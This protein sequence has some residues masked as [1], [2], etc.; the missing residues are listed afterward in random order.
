[1]LCSCSLFGGCLFLLDSLC[2]FLLSLSR[3][4]FVFLSKVFYIL[5][6]PLLV[7]LSIFSGL[8]VGS[9]LF[10]ACLTHTPTQRSKRITD[11]HTTLG[12]PLFCALVSETV[13]DGEGRIGLLLESFET[14]FFFSWL[15]CFGVSYVFPLHR[16][17]QLI[18]RQDSFLHP[19]RAL[20]S[21]LSFFLSL[22]LCVCVFFLFFFWLCYSCLR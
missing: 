17:P 11:T 19:V 1:M 13:L 9:L 12:L 20:H 16:S 22:S 18:S 5:F 15:L 10:E 7:C 21:S 14:N 8:L 2:M 6:C 3:S 4:F